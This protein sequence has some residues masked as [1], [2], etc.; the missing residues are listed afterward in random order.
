MKGNRTREVAVKKLDFKRRSLQNRSLNTGTVAK[1]KKKKIKASLGV[2]L[3]LLDKNKLRGRG[4]ESKPH[5][6][7]HKVNR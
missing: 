4:A 5:Q 6:P 3:K 7:Q 1:N 2:S